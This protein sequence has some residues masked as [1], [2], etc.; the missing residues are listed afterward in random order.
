MPFGKHEGME[1][2]DIPKPYLRW[3][4]NQP[5]LGGW[6]LQEI[7]QVLGDRPVETE[8]EVELPAFSVHSPEGVGQTIVNS[9]GEIIVWTTDA[10]VSQVVCRLLNE[11]EKLLFNRKGEGT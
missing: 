5:W 6:L 11:N 1:L 7:N 3:L 2:T 4:R 9:D 10:W 8:T